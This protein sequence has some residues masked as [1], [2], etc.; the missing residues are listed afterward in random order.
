M[1]RRSRPHAKGSAL[2]RQDLCE[3][4]GGAI[5]HDRPA[6]DGERVIAAMREGFFTAAADVKPAAMTAERTRRL[7]S[8]WG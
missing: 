4:V 7:W 3:L 2:A 8:P 6:S 5:V 1:R